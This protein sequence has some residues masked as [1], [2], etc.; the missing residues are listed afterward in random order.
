MHSIL[1]Q[2]LK[3][4]LSDS[5]FPSVDNSPCDYQT[6]N[7]IVFY[8]GGTTYEEAR[9]VSEFNKSDPSTNII[10]GGTT[11]HNSKT[12]I[13]ECTDIRNIEI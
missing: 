5:D 4:K 9:E 2:A 6:K 3:G 12:F 13:A 1:E 11:I 10:L 7:I 8:L